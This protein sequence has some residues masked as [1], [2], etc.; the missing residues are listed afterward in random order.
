MGGQGVFMEEERAGSGFADGDEE[1]C[2]RWG[3]V[4][5]PL[6]KDQ[7]TFRVNEERPL[8][9][10][11]LEREPREVVFAPCKVVGGAVDG[12]VP[13]PAP[14]V[15]IVIQSLCE[16]LGAL[17]HGGLAPPLLL[18]GALVAEQVV[19]GI[20]DD[21]AVFQAAGRHGARGRLL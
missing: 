13:G 2:R 21:R 20:G 11:R 18:S 1:V 5:P 14:V 8:F 19:V 3:I 6:E 15:L 16:L 7:A 4:V 9:M 10:I 12:R 17:N